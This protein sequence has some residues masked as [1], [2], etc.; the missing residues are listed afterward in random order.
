M[1]SWDNDDEE[2]GVT[3]EDSVVL[4]GTVTTQLGNGKKK[5]VTGF[6]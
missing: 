4:C 5:G 1:R 2:E 6:T 3:G